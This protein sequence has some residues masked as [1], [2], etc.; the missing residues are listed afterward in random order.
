MAAEQITVLGAGSWGTALAHHLARAGHRVTLWGRDEDV[1]QSVATSHAN[2]KYFPNETLHPCILTE[3]SLAKAVEKAD[4]VVL[5]VPSDAVREVAGELKGHLKAHAVLVS[6]AKGLERSTLKT[7]SEVLLEVLG[8][9]FPVAV[10]A[11]PSFALEVLRGLPTAV[12]MA[13]VDEEVV[14]KAA[15]AFHF[16]NM[17]VYTLHDVIGVEYG[18]VMKNVLALA[19]GVVDGVGMGQ[20]ARAAIITRGLVEMQRVVVALGGD[21]LTVTGLSGLGDLLLTAT[22]DL[23]RNRQVGVRLGKGEK[24]DDILTSLGQV[25]EGVH[26]ARMVAELAR[27]KNISAPIVEQIEL[28]LNGS[29]TIR[30]AVEALLARDRKHETVL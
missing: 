25:A 8:P 13:A 30:Q 27:Q 23:S 1:L 14:K 3:A 18:G 29:V 22:G 21:R 15:A 12:T 2:P 17:R 9:S 6:T 24:L 20:N 10:L 7:M 19:A 28:V 5:A 4:I 26:S 11:G 16:D